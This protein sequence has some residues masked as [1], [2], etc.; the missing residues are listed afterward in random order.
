MSAAGLFPHDSVVRRVNGERVLLLG[1][2]RALLMQLAHPSVAQGVAEHSDFQRDPFAR[3]RGTLDAVFTIVF[4]TADEASQVAASVRAVHTR[5]TGPGY[6]A[7]D[8]ALL[9][10][11]H[12]TLVDTAL[13]M[14]TRFVGGLSAD[15]AEEYYQQSKLVAALLGCPESAQPAD[16]AEFREYVRSMVG[17]LVVGDQARALA[18]EVLHPRAPRVVEPAF[19]V[20][21]QLTVGLLP[22]P[23]RAGYGLRWDGPRAAVLDAAARSSRLV[24]PRL[25][26]FVRRG[27]IPSGLLGALTAA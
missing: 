6:N 13:R 26:G 5:V 4:G 16:L 27:P 14:Y 7:N 2:G 8:P 10:W 23:L 25:P 1:G 24:L 3:L 12:A 15:E 21:R 11:V 20:A 17:S 9:L 19:E 22:P 18:R